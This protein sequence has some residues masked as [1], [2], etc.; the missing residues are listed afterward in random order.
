MRYSLY[1]FPSPLVLLRG[2]QKR[3]FSASLIILTSLLLSRFLGIVRDR[4]LT[5]YFFGGLEWQ[6][7]V[8]Y[9]AFRIPDTLYQLIISSMIA[10]G[11]LPIFSRKLIRESQAKAFR[12]AFISLF[13]LLSLFLIAVFLIWP[14]WGNIINWLAP[15]F[16]ANQRKVF[17]EIVPFI[18]GVQLILAV[19]NL[20]ALILQTHNRFLAPAI[21]PLMYN[22]GIIG[23]II[24]L[25]PIFKVNGLVWGVLLGG[26]GH[27]LIQLPALVQVIDG[28][29]DLNFNFNEVKTEIKNLFKLSLPNMVSVFLIQTE[30]NWLTRLASFLSAGSLSLFNLANN[31]VWLPISVFSLALG[32]AIFP[33]LA[34]SNQRLDTKKFLYLFEQAINQTLFIVTP[35]IILF[36]VLR[37]PIVRLV[38]GS[39]NFSW[40]NTIITANLIKIMIPIILAQSLS[41][42][43]QKIF[44]ALGQSRFILIAQLTSTFVFVVSTLILLPQNGNILAIAISLSLASLCKFVLGGFLL[45]KE[46]QLLREVLKRSYLTLIK[47]VGAGIGSFWLAWGSYRLVN[48]WLDTAYTINLILLVGIV[49]GI[50]LLSYLLFSYGFKVDPLFVVINQVRSIPKTWQDKEA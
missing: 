2:Q 44:L 12:F 26:V 31:L 22:L 14:W 3:V 36:I 32:Q 6:L 30:A 16:D 21:S 35:L 27:L 45:F 1:R 42:T 39:K 8:Y 20:S 15:G 7:D 29:L 9:A 34:L 37:L 46:N 47:I 50:T 24:F 4:L 10:A 49:G 19:S 40:E 48:L 41:V 28:K 43:F 25:T 18:I 33:K 13:F 38:L 11:F 5:T 23:G 17:L